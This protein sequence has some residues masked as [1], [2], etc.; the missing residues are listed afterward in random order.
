VRNPGSPEGVSDTF[1]YTL[2][3]DA[4]ATDTANLVIN[5]GNLPML[6][7]QGNQT[8]QTANGVV[9]LPAGV[10][11]SDVRVV[12][13]DLVVTFPTARR[14]SS[15]RRDLRSAAGRRRRRSSRRPTLPRC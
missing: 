4:G 6:Q 11:L 9:V 2:A 12:G 8:I 1:T 3:N 14:W 15:R 5:I 10:E 7:A 13:R